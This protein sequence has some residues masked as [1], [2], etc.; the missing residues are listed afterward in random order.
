MPT[1]TELA[2]AYIQIVP[3]TEGIEGKITEALG[4]EADKAGI[5]AGNT[6][7]KSFASSMAKGIAV[8]AAAVG[9]AAASL[10]SSIANSAVKVSEYGDNV[11]KMSQKI[12]ISA[13][14]YQKWDYVMQRAGTSVDNLKT[15]MK[16]LVSAAQSGSEAFD[17][18]GISQEQIASMSQEQLLEATIKSLDRKSVV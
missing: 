5:A 2:T 13:E 4:G 16:T 1:G 12:G 15:G 18:L 11:D 7:G 8:G 6:A 17:Q 10:V 9:A 3:T 14:S